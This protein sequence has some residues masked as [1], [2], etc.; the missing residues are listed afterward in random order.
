MSSQEKKYR[1][2]SFEHIENV[3]ANAGAKP[4]AT[5]VSTHYYAKQDG[6]GATKLVAHDNK[7]FA[8]HILDEKDGK[9]TLRENISVKDKASGLQWLREHGFD[10]VDVVEMINTDYEY[11]GGTIGLYTI[12]S[13]LLSVILYY[14]IGEHDS[15]EQELGLTEAENITMPYNVYLQRHGQLNVINLD[16]IS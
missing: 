4:V 15:L 13:S 12:N 7:T 10:A 1:V 11:K 16:A 3:L 9:F 8:I 5:K 2:A 6:L 14:P